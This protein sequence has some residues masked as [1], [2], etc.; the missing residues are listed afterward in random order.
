M[1]ETGERLMLHLLKVQDN[2]DFG[3][4]KHDYKGL[5]QTHNTWCKFQVLTMKVTANFQA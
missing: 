3:M 5:N 2:V 4:V 1:R